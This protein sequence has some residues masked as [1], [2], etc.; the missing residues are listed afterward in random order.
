MIGVLVTGTGGGVGQSIIKALNISHHNC[1]IVTAD[2]D[3][4]ASGIYRGQNGYIVPPAQDSLNFIN[5]II[6]ICNKEKINIIF[7]GS[8]PELLIFAYNKKRIEQET[9]ALVVISHPDIIEIGCDKWKTYN[10]LKKNNLTYPKTSLPNE[11]D[12]LIDNIGFPLIVKPINGSASRDVYLTNN[13]KELEIFLKRI[14]NPIIQEYLK[15]I[16]NEF[17]SSIFMLEEEILGVITI[18][19]ELRDGN[20]YRAFIDDYENVKREVKKIGKKLKPFGPC[21]IQ[22][23]LTE[24]G[25]ITFEINPRFSGTTAIRA[26]AGFNEPEAMIDYLLF[27]KKHKLFYKRGIAMRYWNEIYIRNSDYDIIKNKNKINNPNSKIINY[28]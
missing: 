24:K 17:T 12:K 19:R 2:I 6:E 23:C 26:Y 1:K 10:F 18:K 7:I 5:K 16:D 21:N 15:P 28:F 11:M 4:L 25:P 3:E 22:M 13:K 27:N 8:D 9:N 14:K 20:T